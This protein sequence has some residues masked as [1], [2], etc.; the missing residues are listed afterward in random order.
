MSDIAY[1]GVSTLSPPGDACPALGLY[2]GSAYA[3]LRRRLAARLV[4][5]VFLFIAL[6]LCGPLAVTLVPF[7]AVAYPLTACAFHWVHTLVLEGS[8]QLGSAGKRLFQLRL[9]DPDGSRPT[10]RRVFVRRLV[11]DLAGAVVAAAAFVLM[12][13][14]QHGTL[15]DVPALAA[16][17]VN[18]WLALAASL[19]VGVS[20]AF[21]RDGVFVS[22]G[23]RVSGLLVLFV[24]VLAPPVVRLPDFAPPPPLPLVTPSGAEQ[25]MPPSEL[26]R[27]PLDA[28]V[29]DPSAQTAA[30]APPEGVVPS[31][32][33]PLS[34]LSDG[35]ESRPSTSLADD[36]SALL[37]PG[38]SASSPGADP[39]SAAPSDPAALAAGSDGSSARSVQ[40]SGAPLSSA[41]HRSRRLGYRSLRRRPSYRD[42]V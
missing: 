23:E 14:R 17:D 25:P 42:G 5:I 20:L 3:P 38:V 32:S 36:L 4:D 30:G 29:T 21:F 34:S 24:P 16:A 22:P 33:P 35:A 26:A 41:S 28:S 12:L 13:R 7:P 2:P 1:T 40:S 37:A 18:V 10:R 19:G 15:A 39:G 11:D 9:L 27:I 31:V 8:G 6:V